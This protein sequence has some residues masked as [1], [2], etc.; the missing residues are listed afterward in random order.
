MKL[1]IRWP[2]QFP[3]KKGVWHKNHNLPGPGYKIHRLTMAGTCILYAYI[4]LVGGLN[5]SEKI[6]SWDYDIPNI[7]KV[8][9]FMFQTTN[10]S[11]S[12]IYIYPIGSM[13]DIYIY[14]LTWIPSIYLSH[15]SIYVNIHPCPSI[16]VLQIFIN[17][18]GI[19][20]QTPD[21]F[22]ITLRLATD[23]ALYTF[24]NQL[25]SILGLEPGN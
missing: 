24:T 20:E 10:Q 6:V 3:F 13:Y 25:M 4:H 15:L 21:K 12:H 11:Y 18:P 23:Y 7:W 8:I 1:G 22:L 5:P 2:L 9:K 19:L 14:K 16:Y 17:I